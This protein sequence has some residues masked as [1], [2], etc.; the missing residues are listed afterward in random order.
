M[1]AA[2]VVVALIIMAGAWTG[3]QARPA[4]ALNPQTVRVAG[5]VVPLTAAPGAQEE[6]LG[7][8]P[9]HAP[10]ADPNAS[11]VLVDGD[12]PSGLAG[13]ADDFVWPK[14]APAA[15]PPAA[16]SEPSQPAP[17]AKDTP[18]PPPKSSASPKPV[19]PSGTEPHTPKRDQHAT[20]ARPAPPRVKPPATMADDWMRPPAQIPTR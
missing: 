18:S 10:A 20:A 13:R 3:L 8:G 16:Q 6:L 19:R 15:A 2:A 14:P 12:P 17:A 9:A 4:S 1:L 5:P 7:A 11:K